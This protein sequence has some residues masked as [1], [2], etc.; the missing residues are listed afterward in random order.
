MSKMVDIINRPECIVVINA[1]TPVKSSIIR[2]PH[3]TIENAENHLYIGDNLEIMRQLRGEFSGLINAAYLDPPYPR[4]HADTPYVDTFPNPTEWI[5][6]LRPRLQILKSLLSDDGV[7]M[8][9]ANDHAIHH[10]RY[11]MDDV[12]GANY[13]VGTITWHYAAMSRHWKGR[14]RPAAEWIVVYAKDQ[15]FI[16]VNSIKVE[17]RKFQNVIRTVRRLSYHLN[18][19]IEDGLS[20][21]GIEHDNERGYYEWYNRQTRQKDFFL[22]EIDSVWDIP[23]VNRISPDYVPGFFGQKPV[24]LIQ[25][26]LQVFAGP[27]ALVL[28]PFAGTGTTAQAVWELNAQNNGKRRFIL[29]QTPEPVIS[30]RL[31]SDGC[32]VISDIT[33]ARLERVAKRLSDSDIEVAWTLHHSA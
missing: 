24:E 14:I 25:R 2:R 3:G 6:W 32:R 33:R 30:D 12:F 20:A 27:N 7:A 17:K 31:K 13:Y 18:F 26:L 21:L 23:V 11:M 5:A 16:T 8:I 10:L 1:A 9:S 19:P 28:D 29:I 15:R 4:G 22:T